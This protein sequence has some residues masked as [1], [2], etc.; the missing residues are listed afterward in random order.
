MSEVTILLVDD[1]EGH[2]E[3]VRRNLY[4]SGIRNP[5]VSV[6]GGEEALDYVFRRGPFTD[7]SEN[8]ELLILLDIN[9]PGIDGLEV[10]RR[11]KSDAV[12]RTI[13]V[14]MLTTTDDPREIDR[15]YALG[16]NVYI[17]K[18]VNP[19]EFVEAIQRLGLFLAVVKP[20]SDP[21]KP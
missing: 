6:T 9:M 18:P 10:L 16:C 1:D 14:L 3:L 4:R 8:G 5:I 12:A 7:R 13:P 21:V 17:T 11:I 19:S 20:P 15:S 2:T